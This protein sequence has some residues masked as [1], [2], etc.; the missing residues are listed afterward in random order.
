MLYTPNIEQSFVV[1]KL[2]FDVN[3]FEVSVSELG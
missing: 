3:I 2:I 1:R